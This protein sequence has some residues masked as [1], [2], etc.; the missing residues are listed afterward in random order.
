MKHSHR[1][2]AEWTA[3]DRC[4]MAWPCR[5]GMWS[6]SGGTQQHYADVA[7]AIRRFEPVTMLVPP[8][9]IA[10]AKKYLSSDIE[11]FEIPI[12]DSWARDS[13]PSFV[14]DE[15]GALAGVCFGFNAW[16]N[17]YQPYDQDAQMAERILQRCDVP[18]LRSSLIA[19]GGGL[20][21]DGEGTLLTTTSCFPNKNRNPNWSQDAIESELKT[22]LGVDKVI[23]LPG[24]PLD[25]ET[26]GHI[27]GIA[28]FSKPGSIIIEGSSNP[29]DPRK[30][31]FDSLRRQLETETDAKGRH[32][33]LLELPEAPG[34][35]AIGDRFCLSYV[36]FYLANGA[37]IAPAYGISLDD[38]VK[39]RLQ[40]Y[41]PHREIVQVRIDHI[42]EG[43]GGIHC[44]TQQQPVVAAH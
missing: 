12:D 24:D 25:D 32:F 43:G 14:H 5:S 29:Q 17:K 33:E 18:A 1:M 22:Q 28:A 27:D 44:I 9:L 21:V 26:D 11:L 30:P 31:F 16:G 37:V 13:G 38:Q 15:S 34:D 10:E 42:A 8:Q 41:F 40:S 4:W 19:E 23:W 35:C 7:H 2:P 20:C 36:N 39:E 3:H 6:E